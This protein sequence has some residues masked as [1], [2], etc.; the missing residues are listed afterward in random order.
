V[1][2]VGHDNGLDFYGETFCVNPLGE[3]IAEPVAVKES[4]LMA[5]VD[6][7]MV[8]EVREQSGFFRDRRNPL[9]ADLTATR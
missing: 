5:D 6:F 7:D 9:Y 3:F 4:I 8:K 2:R 1:N